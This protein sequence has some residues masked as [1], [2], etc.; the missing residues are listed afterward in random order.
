M[1]YIIKQIGEDF[2]FDELDAARRQFIE[3]LNQAM[4]KAAIVFDKS[5]ENPLDFYIAYDFQQK[6]GDYVVYGFN[7]REELVRYFKLDANPFHNS[8]LLLAIG[9]ELK[10]L[11]E[12]I[13]QRYDADPEQA[14]A[15][16]QAEARQRQ[17]QHDAE[18][19]ENVNRSYRDVL[20]QAKAKDEAELAQRGNNIDLPGERPHLDRMLWSALLL[21]GKK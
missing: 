4:E 20:R 8:P 13:E 21:K 14:M 2:I 7:L 12:E 1:K 16:L 9:Q 5:P 10:V 3:S 19:A 6:N 15:A 17:S 18:F 11:A